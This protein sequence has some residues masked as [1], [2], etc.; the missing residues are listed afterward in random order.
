LSCAHGHGSDGSRGRCSR[1][2]S[3]DG[4]KEV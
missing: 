2:R 1:R 4:S 3:L